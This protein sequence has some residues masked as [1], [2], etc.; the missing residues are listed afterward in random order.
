MHRWANILCVPC[1]TVGLGM[2]LFSATAFGADRELSPSWSVVA[3]GLVGM[4][5][6]L[7]GAYAKGLERR[8]SSN[9]QS[10][11]TNN[12]NITALRELVIGQYH[13]SG[14]V[15]RMFGAVHLTLAEL[16]RNQ[17][18]HELLLLSVHNRLDQ[19]GI[20]VRPRIVAP[21]DGN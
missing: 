20:G 10:C 7:I 9:E 12:A 4:V 3:T 18:K 19:A 11:N 15:E 16:T 2:V 1:L 5:V 14:E 6:A 8:I 13:D 21:D 17:Q